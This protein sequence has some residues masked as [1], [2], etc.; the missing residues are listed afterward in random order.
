MSRPTVLTIEQL[1]EAASWAKPEPEPAR[2]ASSP[3]DG[4]R[5]DLAAYLARH[6]V[7]VK[8]TADWSGGTKYILER[9]VWNA[10]HDDGAAFAG[11][12]AN[13]QLAA[14]CA[15]ASCAGRGWQ[16][17]R[18]ALEPDRRARA[19]AIAPS[20][21]SDAARS[22]LERPRDGE[23]PSC[24]RDLVWKLGAHGIAKPDADVI[25][26]AIARVW[27]MLDE[28]RGGEVRSLIDG[29]F[30]KLEREGKLP[31]SPVPVPRAVDLWS[32]EIVPA[33]PKF[34]VANLIRKAG[35][36]LVWAEPSAGK[37]WTLLRWV[38]ELIS[39]KKRSRLTGHPDLFFNS[40]WRRV[41]WIATEEDS[42]TLRYKAEWIRRGLGYPDLDG[43]IRYLFAAAP[44]RRI[45]LD[46]LSEII[47]NEGPLDG[48]ILDSLTGLRPKTVNGERVRWDVDN[49][50]ANEMC[51]RL[52]GLSSE[53]GLAIF[54]VHHT[55]RVVAKGYRGP[56]DWWASADVMLGLVPDSGR[57][58]IIVEKNRDGKRIAPFYLTPSWDDEKYDLTYDGPAITAK[59]TPTAWKVYA[60]M[61]GH[62]GPA[63]AAEINAAGLAARS[64]I[65]TAL[66]SLVAQGVIHDT[67]ERINGSPVYSRVIAPTVSEGAGAESDTLEPEE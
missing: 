24:L 15:H 18:D 22:G 14:S 35:L 4:T 58:K 37:T 20:P 30:L 21:A 61:Q 40:R 41:L 33:R 56:T 42:G 54:L 53:H 45:T 64:S 26:F 6:G 60:W 19:T 11:Q 43:E 2:P 27:G 48:I 66:G 44:G 50:A 17:F 59:L 39:A 38:H 32:P 7:Q 23:R 51:L 67:G 36:H 62:P 29:V 34:T 16:E 52:R 10:E 13:G 46:D 28:N 63:S 1:R 9:C 31:A 3:S 12:R 5:F 55:G 57:T 65:K 8:R 25:G 47:A 49:D